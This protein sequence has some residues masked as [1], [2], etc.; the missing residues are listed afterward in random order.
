MK[1]KILFIGQSLKVGGIERALLEQLNSLDAEKFDVY[2]LLFY[3]GGGYLSSLS[4]SV[5]MLESNR[6]LS[7]MAMTNMEAKRS[8]STFLMRSFMYILSRL[9][10]NRLLYLTVFRFV[11]SIGVYDVCVSYFHDVAPKG[12]YYGCNLFALKKVTAKKK[13]AWIHS[14]SEYANVG[15]ADN[16][17][18]FKQFDTVVNVSNAM[19]LKFDKL[20]IIPERHSK[21]VYNRS[22]KN[23]IKKL[24]TEF[25][26]PRARN[27]P[28]LV[29]VGRLEP[30]KSTMELLKAAKQLK[31]NG[32]DFIWY[33]VGDGCLHSEAKEYIINNN[34]LKNVV[35]TGQIA[36]PYPYINNADLFISGSVTET[37]GLSI[38]EALYLGV[39]VIAYR[40]DAISELIENEKNGIVVDSFDEIYDKTKEL[41]GDNDK[42]KKLKEQASLICDYNEMNKKQIMEV[43]D[44]GEK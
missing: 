34:L 29:T 41:L 43:F 18:I 19:K 13:V 25:D 14:D 21:V 27:V 33:F 4:P 40:Y 39:P 22:N 10:G 28:V 35:L 30:Y 1:T 44:Y 8:L 31:S 15:S 11:K 32:L 42:L 9:F 7:C 38:L 26:V 3:K 17:E 5:H 24:S 36:N 20:E 37:F 2:L 6:I 23:V 16:R 12:L